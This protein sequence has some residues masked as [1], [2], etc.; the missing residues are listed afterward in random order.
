[1]KL[2]EFVEFDENGPNI[3]FIYAMF[4]DKWHQMPFHSYPLG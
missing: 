3:H 1:M 4:Y 2:K